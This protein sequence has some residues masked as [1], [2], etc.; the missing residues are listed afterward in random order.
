M[1]YS[2]EKWYPWIE[3][4][5][6]RRANQSTNTRASSG[7]EAD[8]P[9]RW[10]SISISCATKD[11]DGAIN[12]RLPLISFQ[13]FLRDIWR[14]CIRTPISTDA[15][16]DWPFAQKN[17]ICSSQQD[18]TSFTAS[19]MAP[20]MTWSGESFNGNCNRL[21]RITSLAQLINKQSGI[22]CLTPLAPVS[23]PSQKPSAMWSCELWL[24]NT[25][26]LVNRMMSNGILD[27]NS[28]SSN[29]RLCFL[30][31]WRC[32]EWMVNCWTECGFH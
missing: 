22:A 20:W 28:R 16:R 31:L 25:C 8:P 12:S 32:L 3:S 6:P 10:R 1:L 26:V 18:V 9:K 29:A 23:S 2:P 19:M 14:T 17:K 24:R 13:A 15:E 11:D 30:H 4:S 7:K 27:R 21:A 5:Y